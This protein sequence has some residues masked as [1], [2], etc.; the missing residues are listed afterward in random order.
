VLIFVTVFALLSAARAQRLSA[1]RPFPRGR[2]LFPLDFIDARKRLLRIIPLAELA[3]C[4][5]YGHENTASTDLRL[6]FESGR[7]ETFTCYN[8][9]EAEKVVDELQGRKKHLEQAAQEGDQEWR[10]SLD[11]F[12]EPRHGANWQVDLLE[13]EGPIIA[14]SPRRFWRHLGTALAFS[15]LALLLLFLRNAL[16]D[17]LGFRSARESGS[18]SAYQRYLH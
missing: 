16:S 7:T 17:E 1:Q 5:I 13:A 18:S 15:A 8:Q 2:Y 3:G 4:T 6:K 10:T 9:E 11:L 14:D 12:V